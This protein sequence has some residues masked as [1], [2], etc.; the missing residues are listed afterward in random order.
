[1]NSCDL[2]FDVTNAN[3]TYKF[4]KQRIQILESCLKI[5]IRSCCTHS[6]VSLVSRPLPLPKRVLHR[7]QSSASSSKCQCL[8]FALTSSSSWLHFQTCYVRLY[9]HKLKCSV[10]DNKNLRITNEITVC[11]TDFCTFRKV[12]G[13]RSSNR[14]RLF[15]GFSTWDICLMLATNYPILMFLLNLCHSTLY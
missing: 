6:V 4:L 11:Y 9:M 5:S 14:R 8:L 10:Y 2:T 1:M 3:V 13:I 7:I 12:S 15:A